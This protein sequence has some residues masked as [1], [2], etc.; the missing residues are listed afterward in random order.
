[1]QK[2]VPF[3]LLAQESTHRSYSHVLPVCPHT[4]A[5]EL[6][7]IFFENLLFILNWHQARGI[8]LIATWKRMNCKSI[9][10]TKRALFLTAWGQVEVA[11]FA[12]NK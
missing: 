2:N 10:S 5:N 3:Y 6:R 9:Q 4:N 8:I 7:S 12:K 11:K 1:M